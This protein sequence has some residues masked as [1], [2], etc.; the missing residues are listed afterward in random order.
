[1]SLYDRIL[2]VPWVYDRLRPLVVGG[3]D[4]TQIYTWLQAGK[5][6]VVLDVGCGTGY[7]MQ[8]IGSFREY[9]GFDTDERALVRFRQNYPQ[10]NV[11]L[12]AR[13]VT[14][15]DI[16]KLRPDKVLLMGLLHHLSDAEAAELLRLLR[17]A[18]TVL[19]VITWDT[20]YV[21]GGYLN[22]L[23]AWLDR[24]RSTREEAAYVRLIES[25]GWQI[26]ERRQFRSGNGL[27]VYFATCL[28]P[29]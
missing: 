17:N 29:K 2:G 18:N 16:E 22:N 6:H 11:H 7:A 1:M 21:R 20:V 15:S 10:A 12:H 8:H 27:A 28:T 24:G 25:A 4:L 5:D 19:R 3:F 23:L 26:T 14:A 9:H 13:V